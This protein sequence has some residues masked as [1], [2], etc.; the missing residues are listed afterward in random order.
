KDVLTLARG[1]WTI[2]IGA[3][4]TA[5]AVESAVGRVREGS[6]APPHRRYARRR[7]LYRGGRI[8]LVEDRNGIAPRGCI[9]MTLAALPGTKQDLLG[10]CDPAH[11]RRS[12]LDQAERFRAAGNRPRRNPL[13]QQCRVLLQVLRA[14]HLPE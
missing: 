11:D 14:V 8:P 9:L 1:A 3:R 5:A 7:Y 4:V 12:G 6:A 2:G 13:L 10:G